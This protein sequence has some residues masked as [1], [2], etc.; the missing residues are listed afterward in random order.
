MT[1]IGHLINGQL[2]TPAGR[3]QDVYNP[4]TGNAEKSVL[5]ASKQTVEEAIASAEAAFPRL[6]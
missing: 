5:L 6:A 1:T 2:V 4:A 3:S